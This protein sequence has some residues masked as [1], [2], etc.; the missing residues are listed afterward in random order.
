MLQIRSGSP[1]RPMQHQSNSGVQQKPDI[2]FNVQKRLGPDVTFSK[3]NATSAHPPA[4]YNPQSWNSRVQLKSQTP[5]FQQALHGTKPAAPTAPPVYRPFIPAA[6]GKTVTTNG[7]VNAGMSPP[8]YNPFCPNAQTKMAETFMPTAQQPGTHLNGIPSVESPAF[9]FESTSAIQM[10]KHNNKRGA[11]VAGQ[12][13]RRAAVG[14]N[15]RG[16]A[17]RKKWQVN[18]YDASP[19]GKYGRVKFRFMGQ[20]RK[21]L[22]PGNRYLRKV[23]IAYTGTRAGDYAAA[24]GGQAGYVWH[25][26]HNYSPAT[27]RGTMYLMTLADHAPFHYGGV[28]MYERAH[29]G[30]YG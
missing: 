8:V 21:G 11:F 27:G 3:P 22:N 24:G 29:G 12:N 17:V 30:A 7:P 1:A 25:H 18:R 2:N 26:Y 16:G 9:A 19:E 13:A 23:S 6:Q 15:T 14:L 5:A 20:T 10:A 28:W 4:V